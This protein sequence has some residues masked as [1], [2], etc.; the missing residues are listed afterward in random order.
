MRVKI[1]LGNKNGENSLTD[2]HKKCFLEDRPPKGKLPQR[3]L[4]DLKGWV[5]HMVQVWAALYDSECVNHHE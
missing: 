2:S 5:K 4:A 3:D 1:V